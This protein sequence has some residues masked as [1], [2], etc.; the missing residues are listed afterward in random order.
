MVYPLSLLLIRREDPKVSILMGQGS[1]EG[2]RVGT[3]V[4]GAA[5]QGIVQVTGGLGGAGVGTGH[6]VTPAPSH[7]NG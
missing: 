5:L 1:G 4:M 3:E 7:G 6:G 2:S